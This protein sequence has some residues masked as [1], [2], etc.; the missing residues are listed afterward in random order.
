A[1]GIKATPALL[2]ELVSIEV[3]DKDFYR[4][5][6][7]SSW[8]DSVSQN[9][10]LL[11]DAG[12]V[13]VA[14]ILFVAFVRMLGKTKPDEIPMEMLSS[15]V[16]TEA[17]SSL[18]NGKTSSPGFTQPVTVELIND[19]IRRKPDNIGAALQNWMSADKSVENS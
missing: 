10:D 9:S 4:A 12:A 5:P 3:A 19:M 18:T 14:V 8:M 2:K 13:L 11:R 17:Q 7:N 1:L 6:D 15:Q 16:D